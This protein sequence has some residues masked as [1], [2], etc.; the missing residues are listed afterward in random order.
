MEFIAGKNLKHFKY[1]IGLGT[2]GCLL[3]CILSCSTPVSKDG[4]PHT[5]QRFVQKA[6]QQGFTLERYATQT[7]LL[8]TY[9]RLAHTSSST[10]HVYIEGDGNSWKSKYKLSNNPTPKQP[11]ALALALRDPSPNVIYI[12]R[13]CQY[14]PLSLDQN[15]IAKFWSSHRYAQEV[16]QA[17]QEVLDS[18]KAK[19][20]N[21]DFLLIGFSGGASV[22]ALVASGRQDIKGLITVAGDL[23]HRALNQHHKTSPLYGSQNPMKVAKKLHQLP[24]QHW[25]GS[26]DAIVPSWIAHR[27]AKEINNQCAQ[28]HTLEGAGHH[29]GWEAHWQQILQTP[30]GC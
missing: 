27:F 15:C 4:L 5:T 26:E 22:A 2:I 13:P 9:Q 3:F 23:D 21:K 25:V 24:Q 1:S 6:E 18:I 7:F 17:T 20:Q 8:T 29:Q 16:I 19:R 12:A 28:V 10:V 30:F 14:T 11:L